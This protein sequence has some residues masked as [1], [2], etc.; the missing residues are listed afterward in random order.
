MQFALRTFV[1][2][3]MCKSDSVEAIG[4]WHAMDKH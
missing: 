1:Y 2:S 4:D 3:S